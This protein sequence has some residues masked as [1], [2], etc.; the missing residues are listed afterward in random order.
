MVQRRLTLTG[1]GKGCSRRCLS[2]GIRREN[3]HKPPA[4]SSASAINSPVAPQIRLVLS[5]RYDQLQ[6]QTPSIFRV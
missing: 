6:T 4:L 5:L 3:L 2:I 1:D